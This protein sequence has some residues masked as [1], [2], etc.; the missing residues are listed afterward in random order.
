MIWFEWGGQGKRICSRD[1][2]PV[3]HSFP[4]AADRF[5]CGWVCSHKEKMLMDLNTDNSTTGVRHAHDRVPIL[6]TASFLFSD[7]FSIISWCSRSRAVWSG[8]FAD[9]IGQYYHQIGISIGATVSQ[10]LLESKNKTKTIR[11]WNNRSPSASLWSC[12]YP[13]LRGCC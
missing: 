2:L 13:V 3:M 5:S 11:S 12:G 1:H 4:V 7:W 10:S 8:Q 6:K 9:F